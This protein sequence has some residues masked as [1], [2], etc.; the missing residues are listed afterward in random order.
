MCTKKPHIGDGERGRGGESCG[1]CK[2]PGG[3]RN[4][5][6]G[7]RGLGE[8]SGEGGQQGP[9]SPARQGRGS[10]PVRPSL[11]GLVTSGCP[12]AS[13]AAC[14]SFWSLTASGSS[15]EAG[16][17]CPRPSEVLP[18]AEVLDLWWGHKR[19]RWRAGAVHYP[20]TPD[21][22]RPPQAS[23]ALSAVKVPGQA[24]WCLEGSAGSSS[25]PRGCCPCLCLLSPQTHGSQQRPV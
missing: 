4:Q 16:P 23:P 3:P 14:C 17:P 21:M 7:D 19:A 1:R 13:T 11:L 22:Q 25:L 6:H 5:S 18:G 20:E 8:R 24:T 12:W 10:G 2:G 15:Q 9:E